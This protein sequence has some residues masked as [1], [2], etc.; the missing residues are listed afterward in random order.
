M[1]KNIDSKAKECVWKNIE[2]YAI[3]GLRTL[4]L[5]E[6]I[7]STDEYNTWNEKYLKACSAL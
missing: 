7:I 3:V 1:H 4:L 5:A 6:R 2:R